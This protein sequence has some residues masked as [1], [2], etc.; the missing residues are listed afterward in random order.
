M[1][2]IV[3]IIIIGLIIYVIYSFF[4]KDKRRRYISQKTKI[5]VLKKYGFK[6]QYYLC[7]EEDNLEF[8]HKIPFSKGGRNDVDNLTIL[9]KEHNREL[10]NKVF[11]G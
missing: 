7:G 2:S 1:I 11:H 6:C 3:E 8:S 5:Q 10:G 9:C 4:K